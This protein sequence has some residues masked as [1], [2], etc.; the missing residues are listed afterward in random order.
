MFQKWILIRQKKT[1]NLKQTKK[2]PLRVALLRI[3]YLLIKW[4]DMGFLVEILKCY[5]N[6]TEALT[7]LVQNAFLL[8]S[9]LF[10]VLACNSTWTVY[11]AILDLGKAVFS[12]AAG[13][14]IAH[15][16]FLIVVF[17]IISEFLFLKAYMLVVCAASASIVRYLSISDIASYLLVLL[18]MSGKLCFPQEFY[19]F[20]RHSFTCIAKKILFHFIS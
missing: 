9:S 3:Y 17:Q 5:K 18:F 15:H 13:W 1:H 4:H 8:F 14:V 2:K 11:W 20:Q 6:A 10:W 7:Y 19:I 16:R 12:I